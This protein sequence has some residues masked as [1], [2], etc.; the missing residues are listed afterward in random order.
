MG[1]AALVFAIVALV[2]ALLP[3][4]YTQLA[5]TVVGIV[6]VVLGVWGRKLARD[7]GQPTRVAT[8]GAALGLAAAVLGAVLYGTFLYSAGRVGEELVR[9]IGGEMRRGD[10]ASLEFRQAVEQAIRR[11]NVAPDDTGRAAD[12]RPAA[13]RAASPPTKQTKK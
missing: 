5:G 3:L 10:R 8:V 11:A 2:F 9:K 1:L 12:R 7:Q 13:K 4:V 6:A